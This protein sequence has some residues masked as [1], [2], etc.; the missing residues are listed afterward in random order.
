MRRKNRMFTLIISILFCV[1]CVLLVGCGKKSLSS[2][3]ENKMVDLKIGLPGGFNITP[4]EIIELFEQKN[5]DIKVSTDDA[6]WS[7]YEK[8]VQLQMMS[9][10]CPDIWFL[11]SGTIMSYGALGVAENLSSYVEDKAKSGKYLMLED[12]KDNEGNVWGIPHALQPIALAYNKKMFQEAGLTYPDDNWDFNELIKIAKKLTRQDETGE[13]VHYG[14]ATAYSITV[15]YYPWIKGLGGDVLD[16]T[17]TK[18][19]LSSTSTKKAIQ[20]W[21]DLAHKEKIF[22]PYTVFK[23][24]RG[25]RNMFGL[26]KVAMFFIQYVESNMINE[27][28]PNLEW[29]VALIP[30]SVTGERYVPYVANAWFIYKKAKP[31]AKEAAKRWLDFWL[32]DEVQYMLASEGTNMPINKKAF[33]KVQKTLPPPASREVFIDYLNEAGANL[34]LNPTWNAWNPI[35]AAVMERIYG[36][37]VGV[38]EGIAE[39]HKEVGDILR[40]GV[41]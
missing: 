22:P 11:E 35:V 31:E 7:D 21:A 37:R 20:R 32:S 24:N 12:T 16:K 15:G 28:F 4:K 30:K 3:T 5:P 1:S 23:A 34:D 38:N 40:K 41:R 13:I 39:M 14:F 29:D 33:E 18:S 36:K 2:K 25:T 19:L 17:K 9:N 8:R 6:P 27:E 26:G 10:D